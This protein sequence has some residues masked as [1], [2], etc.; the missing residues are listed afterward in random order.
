MSDSAAYRERYDT[1]WRDLWANTHAG[2]P[3]ARA[4]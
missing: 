2:G 4:R 1:L 3:M